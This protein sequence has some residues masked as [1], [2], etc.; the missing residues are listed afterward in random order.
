MAEARP[1]A[2]G[3][4]A[5]DIERNR[6]VG[7]GVVAD[8]YPVYDRLRESGP[9]HEGTV[10]EAFGLDTTPERLTYTDRPQFAC[11][12][13][14]TVDQVLRDAETF[15]S[16][17]Y[18]ATLGVAI[19][20]SV[21]QMGGAEHRRNRALVQP[22]FTRKEM[23][24]WQSSWV[25]GAVDDILDRL[26]ARNEP[27]D[28]YQE[29]CARVPVFTIASS[30]GVEPADVPRFHEL[31]VTTTGVTAGPEAR[32]AASQEIADYLEQVIARRRREP[33]DDLIGQL[34]EVE[35]E[36][37]DTG[38]RQRLRDSEILSF[39]RVMLPAGAGTTYRGL[40][41]LLY[42]LLEYDQLERVRQDRS[43]LDAAIEESLRWE[44]PLTS[45]GRLCTRDTELAGVK[46]PDGS[47]V[48]AC[49]ASANHDPKR[50]DDPHRFDID[51]PKLPHATFG[52][53]P[54]LCIGMHL[55]RMEMRTALNAVLDRLP[56]LRFDPDAPKPW[57][58]GLLFRMPTALP[59]VW[60]A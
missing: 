41:C 28:L 58:T 43:L 14:E 40:G 52:S 53:G 18:Q 48:T 7:A 36:D 35:V 32:M 24:R 55:A 44:Q 46:I 12:D 31:A 38:E 29:L 5:A 23:E 16:E 22:A 25:Q 60:D 56:G 15:S 6:V 10:S 49:L 1:I 3:A 59:V 57:I 2:V 47:V 51:R 30:F 34:C 4:N 45:V 42:A 13:W 37:P 8:P 27:C 11:Y 33:R 21:I 20:R 19:G 26:V 54:H 9:V 50:W 17:W 39:A